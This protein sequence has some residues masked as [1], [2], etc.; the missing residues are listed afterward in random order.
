MMHR[1]GRKAGRQILVSTHSAE[2][3]ADP[4]IALEEIMLL[5][6]SATGTNIAVASENDE[7][8]ALVEGGML[9]SAAVIPKSAPANAAQLALFGDE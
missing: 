7:A 1:L 6:P 8:R 2:L 4:G 5:T 3:L 9:A